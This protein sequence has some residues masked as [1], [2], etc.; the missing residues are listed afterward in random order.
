VGDDREIPL[1]RGG[2]DH[3]VAG[4]L[5]GGGPF[6]YLSGERGRFDL[7]SVEVVEG[8]AVSEPR[9]VR[10]D[11]WHIWPRGFS[12][13]AFFYVQ[14][15]ER[16]Q[17]HT[18]GFDP[19]AGVLTGS[20]VPLVSAS[21]MDWSLTMAWSPGGERIAFLSGRELVIRS[22]ATGAERRI[23][24]GFR[25]LGVSALEWS[26]DGDRLVIQGPD[27]ERRTTGIH[28]LDLEDGSVRLVLEIDARLQ[29]QQPRWSRD[30]TALF[31]SRRE[32]RS[33]EVAIVHVELET[34]RAR[35]IFRTAAYGGF[36]VHPDER[37]LAVGARGAAPGDADRVI[38][39]PLR[40]GEPRDLA[41]I[42]PPLEI[43]G[44]NSGLEW[45]PDGRHLLVGSNPDEENRRVLWMVDAGSGEVQEVAR[46]VGS[47][48]ALV[49]PRFHPGG[50]EISVVAGRNRWEIW[51]LVGLRDDVPE[52]A[53]P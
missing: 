28:L 48:G 8:R 44:G 9:L 4:W 36:A 29:H 43:A 37:H 30:G 50:R 33:P 49:R 31:V 38:L 11:L 27:H 10:P 14:M 21:S 41:R 22:V 18:A 42:E 16:R 46:F 25:S 40:G 3:Q 1:V 35:E 45:S 34:G 12:H 52:P 51:K 15:T 13:D 2:G 23:R 5:P 32:A 47:G 7:L 17:A 26:P 24:T 53:Q 39:V 20:L 19:R 6:F